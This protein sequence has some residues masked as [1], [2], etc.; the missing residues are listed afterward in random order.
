MGLVRRVL[1]AADMGCGVAATY[2][3][4][5]LGHRTE[6]TLPTTQWVELVSVMVVALSAAALV[7]ALGRPARGFGVL[8]LTVVAPWW[9]AYGIGEKA[10]IICAATAFATPAV[11]AMLVRMRHTRWL[12]LGGAV[13]AAAQLFFLNPHLVIE[14]APV[15]ARNPLVVHHF[16]AV[17]EWCSVGWIAA[18]LWCVGG[19]STSRSRGVH[20]IGLAATACA[21]V[22]PGAAV[23]RVAFD[24][25]WASTRWSVALAGA[26]LAACTA[27]ALSATEVIVGRRIRRFEL[28]L[29]A[30]C[31]PGGVQAL[32]QR[33]LDDPALTVRYWVDGMLA[34]SPT[35]NSAELPVRSIHRNGNPVAEIFTSNQAAL[36][37]ALSPAVVVALENERLA[38]TAH[39]LLEAARDARLRELDAADQRRKQLERDVHDGAQ[40]RLLS[41]SI[42]LSA[43]PDRDDR[44]RRAISHAANALDELRRIAHGLYPVVLDELGL[45]EAI[46]TFMEDSPVAV[47]FVDELSPERPPLHIERLLYRAVLTAAQLAAQA[48]PPSLRLRLL[49]DESGF[50]MEFFHQGDRWSD[51][52]DLADRVGA[53]NGSI[54]L[55]SVDGAHR[56][57]V[58]VG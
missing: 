9:S 42:A 14:C 24:A 26:L 41:V 10:R 25:G 48:V 43:R 7:A 49:A 53:L 32:L 39:A 35:D 15:C 38:V 52:D 16:P 18:I 30:T 1:A 3:L 33:A 22:P 21:F 57:R 44:T 11:V 6:H 58:V 34:G 51:L 20:R 55:E 47:T 31:S 54:N 17:V 5:R 12:V 36:D 29:A 27:A 28:E 45:A 40:Q 56:V 4:V 19:A 46:Y 37:A 13:T 50:V 2:M 8:A 23:G